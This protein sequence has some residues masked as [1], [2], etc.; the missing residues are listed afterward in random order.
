VGAELFLVACPV[1]GR[2]HLAPGA[3]HYCSI[4]CFRQGHG[5]DD[6]KTGDGRHL[7]PGCMRYFEPASASPRYCSPACKLA[8]WKRQQQPP[9]PGGDDPIAAAELV[10]Q[11][12]IT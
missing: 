7:C 5:L 9:S 2:P 12:V 11:E 10:D 6:P 4:I 3:P 1:C 8:D